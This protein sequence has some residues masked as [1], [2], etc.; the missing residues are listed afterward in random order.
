MTSTTD[1]TEHPGIEEISDLTEGLLPPA[2]DTAVRRHL[3]DCAFC[4]DIR[5]SLEEIRG[6]L[7]TVPEPSRMPAE[8]ASRIDAALAAESLPHA[9]APESGDLA[10]LVGT[11]SAGASPALPDGDH[12]YV[13][14]ETSVS[15][16]APEAGRRAGRP[17]PSTT[18]P[19][20]KGRLRRGR[21]GVAVL[22]TA[23]TIAALGLGTVVLS[24]Q[25]EDAGNGRRTTATD[26]FS[27]GKLEKQVSDL[28][29]QN[30]RRIDS[31]RSSQPFGL[32]STSGTTAGPRVL[33]ATV[34]ECVREGI[35]RDDAVLATEEGT[36]EGREALLVVLPD[37]SDDTRV[38]AYIVDAT[39]VADPSSTSAAK[40]LLEHAYTRG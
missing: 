36:Y 3:D 32:E 7:G 26:T 14:R 6:L 23:F 38:T 18:G 12:T 4:A 10:E 9:T 35:G 30:R 22:G 28:L 8:V 2:R 11:E 1:M 24:S 21:H 37:T 16:E 39:C 20:R 13:S 40:V 29:A 31:S 34:P 5:A 27:E 15:R 25:N 17:R 19:G 33:K